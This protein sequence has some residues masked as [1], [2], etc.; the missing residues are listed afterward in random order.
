MALREFADR[1]GAVWRVWDCTSTNIPGLLGGWLCFESATEKRRLLPI[2][3]DWKT[4][5]AHRLELLCRVATPVRKPSG[6]FSTP[7]KR[8]LTGT[9]AT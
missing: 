2:P 7:F 6:G 5:P 3:P 8:S 4:A 1:E 9:R